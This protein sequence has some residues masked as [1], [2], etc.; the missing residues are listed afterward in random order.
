M[1]KEQLLTIFQKQIETSIPFSKEDITTMLAHQ[2]WLGATEDQVDTTIKRLVPQLGKKKLYYGL[3]QLEPTS[4][5]SIM[6]VWDDEFDTLIDALH[7]TVADTN[8]PGNMP[9][10]TKVKA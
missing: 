8:P 3:R 7:D 1:N 9:W 6:Y 10:F 2:K 5:C 4:S